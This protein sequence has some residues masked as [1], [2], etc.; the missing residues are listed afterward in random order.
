MI[1]FSKCL[2]W[3]PSS[4]LKNTINLNSQGMNPRIIFNF[5]VSF[6]LTITVTDRNASSQKYVEVLTP[7]TS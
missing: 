7:C 6:I 5:Q 3:Y 1:C 2:Q 4:V